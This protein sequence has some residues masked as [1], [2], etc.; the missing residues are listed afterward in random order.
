MR[1]IK[2]GEGLGTSER[3]REGRMMWCM[4]GIKEGEGLGTLE[5]RLSPFASMIAMVRCR[6]FKPPLAR[7][8]GWCAWK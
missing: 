5:R 8:V 4:G 2:Q 7:R 1:G 3:R 6:A